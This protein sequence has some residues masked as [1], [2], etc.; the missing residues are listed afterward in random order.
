SC[1][2]LPHVMRFLLPA[3][4]REQGRIAQ[5]MGRTAPEEAADAVEE[6]IASLEVPHRI[7]DVGVDRASFPAIADATLGDIVA[8]ESPR[9]VT[10]ES[11]IE[12]LQAAW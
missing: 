5:A 9:T 6:L 3:T 12:L 1:I 7:R 2:T 10:R 4:Q 11:V 8:R